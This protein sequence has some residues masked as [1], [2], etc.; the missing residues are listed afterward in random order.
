MGGSLKKGG[1]G[2][3]YRLAFSMYV[4]DGMRELMNLFDICGRSD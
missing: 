2:G 1:S 3:N 4:I